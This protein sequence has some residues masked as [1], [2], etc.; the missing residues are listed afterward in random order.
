MKQ[1]DRDELII[2]IDERVK[3]LV[4]HVD[5]QNGRLG[6]LEAYHNKSIGFILLGAAV[7]SFL[8]NNFMA[9]V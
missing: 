5:R 1:S 2:R 8:V 4:D 9:S 7:V 3:D 6:K